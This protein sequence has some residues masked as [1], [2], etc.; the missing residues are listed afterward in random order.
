MQPTTIRTLN[1][2]L[3]RRIYATSNGSMAKAPARFSMNPPIKKPAYAAAKFDYVELS[4]SCLGQ[5]LSE[6]ARE[7]DEIRDKIR[8]LSERSANAVWKAT[9]GDANHKA[10]IGEDHWTSLRL[11]TSDGEWLTHYNKA[12]S[13][14]VETQ[15][16]QL[17]DWAD[18]LVV[19][20]L[21]GPCDCAVTD[22][23]TFIDNWMTFLEYDDDGPFLI[24]VEG[25]EVLRV[26]P[27]GTFLIGTEATSGAPDS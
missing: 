7:L 14:P 24:P 26:S 1:S 4:T 21:K 16:R 6:N 10:A 13:E 2:Q 18:D 9:F 19:I 22:W 3:L 8:V 11:W 17:L 23:R 5:L 12:D 27:H 15:L 20:F 25:A